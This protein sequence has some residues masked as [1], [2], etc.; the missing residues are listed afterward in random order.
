MDARSW[1]APEAYARYR[2]FMADLNADVED[3]PEPVIAE[4]DFLDNVWPKLVAE[5]EKLQKWVDFHENYRETIAE[6]ADFIK[7][8]SEQQ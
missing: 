6:V 8:I 5:P 2:R 1:T 7:S 4:R 3:G